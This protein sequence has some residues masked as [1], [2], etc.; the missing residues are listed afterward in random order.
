MNLLLRNFILHKDQFRAKL[1]ALPQ[2]KR[3]YY[4]LK[5]LDVPANKL[6]DAMVNTYMDK[7]CGFAPFK[8]TIRLPKS[9]V[10]FE[11]HDEFWH[12]MSDL[13][14]LTTN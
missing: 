7:H 3:T 1:L 9:F 12:A 5:L 2:T 8:T 14:K 13:C 4:L 11:N 10:K 6:I